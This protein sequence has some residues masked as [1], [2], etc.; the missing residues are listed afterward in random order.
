LPHIHKHV[1]QLYQLKNLQTKI[2][3]DNPY[4]N[5]PTPYVGTMLPRVSPSK[6]KNNNKI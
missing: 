4:R 5:H 6:K 2:Y 1:L 3:K